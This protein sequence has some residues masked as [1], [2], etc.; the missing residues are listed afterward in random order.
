ML[1]QARS[2]AVGARRDHASRGGRDA[3]NDVRRAVN[4]RSRSKKDGLRPSFFT[5]ICSILRNSWREFTFSPKPL[6]I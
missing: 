4:V 5:V 1:D 6:R 2:R 3:A